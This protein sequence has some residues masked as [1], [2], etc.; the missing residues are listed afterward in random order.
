MY[1]CPERGQQLGGAVLGDRRQEQHLEG[2]LFV[3]L[4]AGVLRV[5]QPVGEATG[6][7]ERAQKRVDA[8]AAAATADQGTVDVPEDDCRHAR[9]RLH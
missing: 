5:G 8:D 6:Q 7:A 1:A 4:T 2:D 9:G 3:G